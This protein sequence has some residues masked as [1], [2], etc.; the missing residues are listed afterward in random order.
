MDGL[1]IVVDVH[2]AWKYVLRDGEPGKYVLPL[3]L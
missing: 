2:L 3:L 1:V